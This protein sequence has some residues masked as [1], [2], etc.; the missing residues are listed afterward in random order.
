MPSHPL[1]SP[2]PPAPQ[3]LP[4]L[5]SFPINLLKETE[6]LYIENYKTLMKE[7]KDDSNRWRSI[8]F[9]ELEESI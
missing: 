2:S 3:S 6:D 8:P 4:A 5:D 1:L 7:I 9:H